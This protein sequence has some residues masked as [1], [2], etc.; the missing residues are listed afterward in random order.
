MANFG[1]AVDVKFRKGKIL[2]LRGTDH[3]AFTA[4]IALTNHLSGRKPALEILFIRAAVVNICPQQALVKEFLADVSAPRR[5]RCIVGMRTQ[6]DIRRLLNLNHEAALAQR[7]RTAAAD[8][9]SLAY[10]HRDLMAEIFQC[11]EIICVII[12]F[13]FF[14]GYALFEAEKDIS[15]FRRVVTSADNIPAF[16]FAVIA[17]PHLLGPGTGRVALKTVLRLRIQIL[18]QH[19]KA[20][21]IFF[22][23]LLSQH[24]FRVQS[25][26][27]KEIHS[28]AVRQS[29]LTAS[30]I[31]LIRRSILHMGHGADPCFGTRVVIYR[32][33]YPAEF[34]NFTSALAT[35]VIGN[36]FPRLMENAHVL[37]SSLLS[38]SILT[39]MAL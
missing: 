25:N 34:V 33:I 17:V 8:K 35:N 6:R 10:L 22:D 30:V 15:R 39:E 37:L 13:P 7:V 18:N 14:T 1:F 27:L 29:D 21:S 16:F 4:P 28:A 31:G 9:I 3:N 36:Q 19:A 12:L 11:L 38:V 24:F 5:R 32:R 2:R 23:M 26:G 20:G